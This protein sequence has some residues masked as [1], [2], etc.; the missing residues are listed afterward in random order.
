MKPVS[1][2]WNKTK[3]RCK[4]C[5]LITRSV[6]RHVSRVHKKK[7]VMIR[8]SELLEVWVASFAPKDAKRFPV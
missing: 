1:V 8:A 4:I 3:K 6:Y 7:C 5:N 2:W